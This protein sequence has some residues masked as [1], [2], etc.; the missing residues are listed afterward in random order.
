MGLYVDINAYD[1]GFTPFLP[2]GV[3]A[4]YST[5]NNILLDT[6]VSQARANVPVRTG[7]LMA[8]ITGDIG[9]DGTCSLYTDCEYAQYV[10]YGTWK[11]PAQPF[12]EDA[13]E[14]AVQRASQSWHQTLTD[15]LN[16]GIRLAQLDAQEAKA[17]IRQL[18]EEM[19]R[20]YYRIALEVFKQLCEEADRMYEEMIL[21][22]GNPDAAQAS[23]DS[24]IRLAYEIK[25]EIEDTGDEVRKMFFKQA[26]ETYNAIMDLAYTLA[27]LYEDMAMTPTPN[28]TVII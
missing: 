25:K 22:G 7:N 26:D 12:F 15:G 8:S 23:R 20:E 11:A 19:R 9:E 3:I 14:E 16:Q 10:E 17:S 6:F 18:G 4:D 27:D 1:F 13:V 24:L 21:E 5:G 28:E 2:M